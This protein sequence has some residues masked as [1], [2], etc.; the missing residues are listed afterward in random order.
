V[1][2]GAERFPVTGSKQKHLRQ[3]EF[4]FDG[5]TIVGIEQNPKT[6][7]RW[8]QMARSG[9]KA[10][11]LIFRYTAVTTLYDA[12]FGSCGFDLVAFRATDG[13]RFMQHGTEAAKVYISNITAKG[14]KR[15]KFLRRASSR[16]STREGVSSHRCGPGH[17]HCDARGDK[18][19]A[20]PLREEDYCLRAWDRH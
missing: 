8:A 11:Q 3:V 15:L 4:V 19:F 12:P 5:S 1:K 9:K 13:R 7:S 10:M 20:E 14:S 16:A 2:L 6:K 17:Q 18:T